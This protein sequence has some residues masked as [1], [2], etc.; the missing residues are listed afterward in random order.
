[1]NQQDHFRAK[2]LDG[3]ACLRQSYCIAAVQEQHRI[4]CGELLGKCT[5]DSAG[6]AC[7]EITLHPSSEIMVG[8]TKTLKRTATSRLSLVKGRGQGE[9][10]LLQLNLPSPS[11]SSSLTRGEAGLNSIAVKWFCA[12]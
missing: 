2:R 11:S 12:R 9:G 10:W 3:F 7:D 6:R 8:N 1:M 4:V 5:A